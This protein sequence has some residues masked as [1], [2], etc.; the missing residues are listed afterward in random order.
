MPASQAGGRG[1]DP[2]LPLDFSSAHGF[3]EPQVCP[4]KLVQVLNP[5]NTLNLT[6]PGCIPTDGL[7][8]TLW[9]LILNSD[10]SV[11]K[12]TQRQS[13]RAGQRNYN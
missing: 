11:T 2:R 1:F 4:V 12:I 9:R 5:P 13:P 7:C 10:K 8:Q 6:A 3:P